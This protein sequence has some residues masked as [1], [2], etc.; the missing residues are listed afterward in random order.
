MSQYRATNRPKRPR[1][2]G[3]GSAELTLERAAGPQCGRTKPATAH[4]AATTG[5]RI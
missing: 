2:A 1:L 4:D 5:N 3:D